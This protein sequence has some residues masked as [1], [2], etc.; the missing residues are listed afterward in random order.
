MGVDRII[1]PKGLDEASQA[2]D[3]PEAVIKR[4]CPIRHGVKDFV[5]ELLVRKRVR[6][7]RGSRMSLED[8]DDCS[9]PYQRWSLPAMAPGSRTLATSSWIHCFGR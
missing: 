6:V 4:I 8:E 9:V 5:P 3:R 1:V 2:I 7:P